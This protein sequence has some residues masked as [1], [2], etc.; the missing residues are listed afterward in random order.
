MINNK[1]RE[2]H[3][4]RPVLANESKIFLGHRVGDERGQIYALKLVDI[5]KITDVNIS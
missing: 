2:F 1:Q 3:I 5:S 4:I